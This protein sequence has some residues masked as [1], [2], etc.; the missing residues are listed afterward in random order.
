MIEEIAYA[1]GK[2]PLEVRKRNFYGSASATSRPTTRRSRTTSSPD[3]GRAGAPRDYAARPRGGRA[4]STR[5]PVRQAQGHRADAGEVRHLLHRHLLQPGRRAGARLQRRLGPPEPR[6]HR[7]GAG[8][9]HQGG[10][11]GGRRVPGRPR[12]GE[13]HR[14][15][16]RQ[17]AEHLGDGGL[18]GL[19]PERHGG[20]ERGRADQGA[21]GRLRR[22]ALVGARGT[23]WCSSRNGCGSATRRSPSR[24]VAQAYLG[25]VQLSAAGFYKTPKIHWDRAAGAGRPFYYFAYGAAVLARS[26]RHADRRVPRGPHRHPARRRPLAEPGDRSSGQVEGGF[27][28]GM[29][30]LTTEE[31]WWDD[32]GRLRTHAPST[33]KIPLARDRPGDLQREARRLV[34]EPRGRRSAAPRRWA[35]RRSC[36]ASRCSRRCRWRSRASPTTGCARGS[37]RRRRPSAC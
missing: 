32:K 28:Q 6:R 14:D 3:G 31:L 9:L 29:G 18:L 23:R 8:A 4:P 11:G 20:A 25:R 33:Y 12:P 21:A 26:R 2:D 27:I 17:G 35:S 19:R 30:W 24:L 13:D 15:H 7:D 37:T 22:R 34:G 1:L 5:Q 10:A 36:S 16:H